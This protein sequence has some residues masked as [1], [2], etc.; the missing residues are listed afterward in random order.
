[1]DRVMATSTST[2]SQPLSDAP[3]AVEGRLKITEIF[4]SIQGESSYAG[5]RCVFIRLTGCHLRCTWCDTTYSFTGGQWISLAELLEKVAG[6]GCPLV[7]ITGGEPLLQPMVFPLM[8]A[9]CDA[10]YTVLL[11]T[12]GACDLTPVDA[13]VISIVDVKCPGSGESERNVWS[14]LS[15][16]RSQDEVKFVLADRQDY[17]WA[18]EIIREYALDQRRPLP[19]L[20]PVYGTLSLPELASWILDD[21]LA[22]RFQ[23]QLHKVVWGPETI[24]V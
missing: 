22:V 6:Y 15:I 14:N 17:L 21:R 5:Q 1:M 20:S 12:S 8:T 7:E 3:V 2:A 24:G 4:Y 13:R 16:L 11:E 19:L 18:R 10:G 9:L 23:V